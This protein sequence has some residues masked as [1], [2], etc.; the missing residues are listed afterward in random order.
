MSAPAPTMDRMFFGLFV[1]ALFGPVVLTVA[2]FLWKPSDIAGLALFGTF[3]FVA[4]LIVMSLLYTP[5]Q[6]GLEALGLRGPVG[7]TLA[8]A[9]AFGVAPFAFGLAWLQR[10]PTWSEIALVVPLPALVVIP[11]GGA[12]AG[13]VAWRVAHGDIASSQEKSGG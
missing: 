7:A 2:A 10:W 4:S 9:A 13:F 1:G 8:G 5:A 6:L 11:I 3:A 12:V